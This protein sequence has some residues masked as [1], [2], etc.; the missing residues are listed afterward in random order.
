M[1]ITI[2]SSLKFWD[3]IQEVK[4]GLEELG[5]T[6][7]MPIKAEGVDYWEEDGSKRV[8]AKKTQ[9]LISEHMEKIEQSDAILVANY[10]KKEIEN[11]I[12]A[13]TFLEIGFAHHIGKKIYFLNPIPNQPYIREELEAVEPIILNR[14]L[15]K[16]S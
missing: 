8:A 5:Y 10:T 9:E 1:T 14:D 12:G 3:E 6:I 15:S 16:V 4:E 7:Y 11:Y 2:C 13:N